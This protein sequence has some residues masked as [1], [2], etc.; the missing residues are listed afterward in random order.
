MS[1]DLGQIEGR[2]HAKRSEQG[3]G[4]RESLSLT[5]FWGGDRDG[6][7]IQITL[8][9]EFVQITSWEANLLAETILGALEPP[10]QEP[11]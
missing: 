4:L 7:C 10:P 1:T 2:P 6:V 9:H 8:S 11:V 5:R 3:E